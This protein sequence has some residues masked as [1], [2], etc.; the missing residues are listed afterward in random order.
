MST[1]ESSTAAAAT[2]TK[3]DVSLGQRKNGTNLAHH[4]INTVVYF[5]REITLCP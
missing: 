3:P 5:F 1:T 4:T 2:A